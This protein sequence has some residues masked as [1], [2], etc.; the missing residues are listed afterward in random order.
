MKSGTY[1]YLSWVPWSFIDGQQALFI[2]PE[3]RQPDLPFVCNTS[4]PCPNANP[5]LGPSL[6]SVS[7]SG[8]ASVFIAAM[9]GMQNLTVQTPGTLSWL[10][11]P[12]S[13]ILNPDGA[14]CVTTFNGSLADPLK[15]QSTLG[16]NVTIMPSMFFKEATL[17]RCDL[18]NASYR[19]T[20]NYTSGYQHIEVTRSS[21]HNS[22]VLNG[23]SFI[24]GPDAYYTARENLSR[25]NCSTF[26]DSP[27][28]VGK[29]GDL[30]PCEFNLDAVRKLSY[31]G[32]MGAFNELLIGSIS[33]LGYESPKI[34][35]TSA[36]RTI[37]GQTKELA[38]LRSWSPA[39]QSGVA[40]Y[41]ESQDLQSWLFNNPHRWAYPG[42]SNPRLPTVRGNLKTT[43]EQLFQNVTISVLAEPYFQ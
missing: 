35:S 29:G 8:P 14:G 38:F 13:T 1:V 15:C 2:N 27:V 7:T 25:A 41:L 18:V 36:M 5:L 12:N 20:F 23:T 42:L 31:E 9:P 32:I 19:A 34:T 26:L 33:N 21:T 24:R 3:N 30:T 22:T 4:E 40:R 39:L 16:K 28:S 37:L 10:G 11:S 17:L 6:A 43:L